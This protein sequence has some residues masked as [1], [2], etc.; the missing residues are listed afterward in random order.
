MVVISKDVFNER[1]GIVNALALT[2]REQRAGFPLTYELN[3]AF[4][5]QKSWVKI[6]QI[7][8]V[9]I[10]RIKGGIGKISLE[11]VIVDGLNEIVDS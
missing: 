1:S 2:S 9:S 6:S 10:A 8:T 5:P 7:K 11:H 3:E 4:L